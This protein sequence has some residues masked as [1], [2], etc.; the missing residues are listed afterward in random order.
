MVSVFKSWK[1]SQIE[2]LLQK[3]SNEQ[4]TY[5]NHIGCD[6][7]YEATQ[8]EYDVE[9][10]NYEIYVQLDQ[11][12]KAIH[13][14]NSSFGSQSGAVFGSMVNDFMQYGQENVEFLLDRYPVLIYDGNFDII[15]NHPGILNMFAKMQTWSGKAE[16]DITESEAMTF[17]GDTYGY[18]KSVQNLRMVV[19]RNAGHMVPRSQP[20]FA[21]DMFEKFING[22]L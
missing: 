17:A 13:V 20:E 15:C 16:Y 8:C 21:L 6:Y 14:G 3:W 11:T 1:K 19:V 12:R 9:E 22:N 4:S 2:A 5:L 10:D 18:L 7:V